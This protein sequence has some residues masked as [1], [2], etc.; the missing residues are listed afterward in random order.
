LRRQA[1][2]ASSCSQL[3]ALAA[4]SSKQ[5]SSIPEIRVGPATQLSQ[6][7]TSVSSALPSKS[8]LAPGERPVPG[9]LALPRQPL[10][11]RRRGGK[12]E[13]AT[14]ASPGRDSDG[15]L[16]PLVRSHSDPG[17]SSSNS[18]GEK[19]FTKRYPQ[20]ANVMT[21]YY[22]IRHQCSVVENHVL[23]ID[24]TENKMRSSLFD[25]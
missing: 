20:V 25:K 14:A 16:S 18:T 17:L 4:T 10:F 5:R 9:A 12:G 8:S 7:S 15:L 6:G 11:L 22:T 3:E 1:L 24:E 2:L 23:N 13:H 21:N 19:V